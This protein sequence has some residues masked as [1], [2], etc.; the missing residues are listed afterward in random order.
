MVTGGEFIAVAGR[1]VARGVG[2]AWLCIGSTNRVGLLVTGCCARGGPKAEQ[3]AAG[4]T[5]WKQQAYSR[6]SSS[7]QTTA[8]Y[9]RMSKLMSSLRL[10]KFARHLDQQ[11]A[12]Q[13]GA[14]SGRAVAAHVIMAHRTAWRTLQWTLCASIR[15]LKPRQAWDRKRDICSPPPTSPG[16]T[17]PR[18][19]LIGRQV[20]RQ[21]AV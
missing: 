5:W 1:M 13:G 17:K 10:C 7:M 21:R 20:V 11:D 3:K 19:S 12:E 14:H 6:S 9:H 4:G 18:N 15:V 16:A 8:P 2:G